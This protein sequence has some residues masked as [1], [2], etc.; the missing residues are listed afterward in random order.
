VLVLCCYCFACCKYNKEALSSVQKRVV[1]LFPSCANSIEQVCEKL[2]FAKLV[3]KFPTF[4][5]HECSFLFSQDHAAGPYPEPDESSPPP[6]SLRSIPISQLCLYLPSGSFF[7]GFPTK[8]LY[9]FLICF[10]HTIYPTHLMLL[11]LITLIIFYEE[12]KL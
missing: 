10:L 1:K 8:L 2:R 4:L 12:Q 7:S 6:I 3:K 5:K 9:V 11:H